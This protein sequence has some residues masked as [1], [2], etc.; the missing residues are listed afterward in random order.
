M[1]IRQAVRRLG[2]GNSRAN[3]LMKPQTGRIGPS[4]FKDEAVANKNDAKCDSEK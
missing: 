3:R 4:L 2:Y 1:S